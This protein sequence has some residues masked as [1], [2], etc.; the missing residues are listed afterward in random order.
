MKYESKGRNN[1]GG[2]RRSLWCG[3][4]EAG[5]RKIGA[6]KTCSYRMIA[7][8]P[9]VCRDG[10]ISVA[11]AVSHFFSHTLMQDAKVGLTIPICEFLDLLFAVCLRR[12]LGTFTRA[13]IM[14]Q[15]GWKKRLAKKASSLTEPL[16]LTFEPL[17]RAR[18]CTGCPSPSKQPT[19]TSL[20]SC[21][22]LPY[23]S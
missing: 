1:H 10:C 2:R 12:Q 16:F 8:C 9:A 18:C 7:E 17:L 20:F 6:C 13:H 22:R 19:T 5:R 21:T 23:A 4:C 14:P 3:D 11:V 15:G